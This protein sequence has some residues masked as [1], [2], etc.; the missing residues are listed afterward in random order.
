MFEKSILL[1]TEAF[2]SVNLLLVQKRFKSGTFSSGTPYAVSSK[3]YWAVQAG[4]LTPLTFAER[5]PLRRFFLPVRI[6]FTMEGG[7]SEFAKFTVLSLKA[8]LK[9]I[10]NK[11]QKRTHDLWSSEKRRK[12]TSSFLFF[13]ILHHLSPVFFANATVVAFLLLCNSR[14]KFS[15]TWR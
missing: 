10:K 11:K 13:S 8:Y 14:F 2:N 6:V 15:Y 3:C 1:H 12:N 7:D 9:Q 4:L 5:W